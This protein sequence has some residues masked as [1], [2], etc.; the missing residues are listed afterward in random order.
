MDPTP[1]SFHPSVTSVEELSVYALMS[2]CMTINET[3]RKISFIAMRLLVVRHC[4][5]SKNHNLLFLQAFYIQYDTLHNSQNS[6]E[7]WTKVHKRARRSLDIPLER[8]TNVLV[9]SSNQVSRA[10]AVSARQRF[11]FYWN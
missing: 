3:V 11:R 7:M 5:G 2:C 4:T 10:L 6:L 8:R 1:P 9:K